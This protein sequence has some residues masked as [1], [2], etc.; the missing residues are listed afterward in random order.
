MYHNNISEDHTHT[1]ISI[2]YLARASTAVVS[3]THRRVVK[4][5]FAVRN[6]RISALFLTHMEHG[7]SPMSNIR[8]RRQGI[9]SHR[10]DEDVSISPSTPSLRNNE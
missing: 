10:E 2:L 6:R 8:E 9:Q 4:P 5:S 7:R 3:E 1:A